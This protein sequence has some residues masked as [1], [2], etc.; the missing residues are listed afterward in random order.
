[1]MAVHV[2]LAGSLFL[3]NCPNQMLWNLRGQ[4][5]CGAR[6]AYMC[7]YDTN[8]RKFRELCKEK[9]EFHRPGM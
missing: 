7:L 3:N 4:D 9:P 5:L 8:K 6:D 1:M 2:H